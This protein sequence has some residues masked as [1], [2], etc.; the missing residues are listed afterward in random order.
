MGLQDHISDTEISS[1]IIIRKLGMQTY[2][3]IRVVTPHDVSTVQELSERRVKRILVITTE[4]DLAL[5]SI[6][7]T[8]NAGL[9]TAPFD[10]VAAYAPTWD[11]T[12][13]AHQNVINRLKATIQHGVKLLTKL[14]HG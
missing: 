2:G 12:V 5:I 9:K 1:A 10:H 8:G 11:A 14:L 13:E 7:L 6:N 4:C 3:W